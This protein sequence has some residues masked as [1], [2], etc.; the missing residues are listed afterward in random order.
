MLNLL[1][2]ISLD[3]PKDDLTGAAVQA[4]MDTIHHEKTFLSG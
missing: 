4:A 3:N 1:C 2:S